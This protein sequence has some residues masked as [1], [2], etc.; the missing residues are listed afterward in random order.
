[1][2]PGRTTCITL[3]SSKTEERPMVQELEFLIRLSLGLNKTQ[4]IVLEE[5][6]KEKKRNKEKERGG[7][8]EGGKNNIETCIGSKIMGKFIA[9]R[10]T[11]LSIQA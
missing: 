2:L 6:E 1:M 7:E 8:G 9:F 3:L 4:C 5:E 11:F 10:D